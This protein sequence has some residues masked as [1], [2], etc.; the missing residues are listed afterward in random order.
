MAFMWQKYVQGS[1][2]WK[3]RFFSLGFFSCF[4]R[5][6]NPS[7]CF[8]T[9]SFTR[10]LTRD[11]Y[12][13]SGDLERGTVEV[14]SLPVSIEPPTGLSEAMTGLKD[15]IPFAA[16]HQRDFV[17]PTVF[18][19]E[20]PRALFPAD[21]IW[22]KIASGIQVTKWSIRIKNAMIKN[23]ALNIQTSMNSWLR[24][25]IELTMSQRRVHLTWSLL[26]TAWVWFI[27][28]FQSESICE[29]YR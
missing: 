1:D 11:S 10:P 24:L 18:H 8:K 21:E 4:A 7:A 5:D 17:I 2:R 19:N 9:Q 20:T 23:A 3:H 22:Y 15:D 29:W 25:A 14:R 13:G 28:G 16:G 26:C 6:Q 27:S 12:Y